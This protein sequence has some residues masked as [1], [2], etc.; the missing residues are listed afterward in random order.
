MPLDE[1]PVGERT[2]ENCK[3]PLRRG[4]NQSGI[5]YAWT[6]SPESV[7]ARAEKRIAD[8]EDLL[9][10][11]LHQG[12]CVKDSEI[13]TCALSTWEDIAYYFEERGMLVKTGGR[14]FK[15]KEE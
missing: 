10:D 1:L 14:T 6:E 2:C 12:A 4:C 7:R 15:H 11:A 9:M 5:C 3:R 13:D 8:L